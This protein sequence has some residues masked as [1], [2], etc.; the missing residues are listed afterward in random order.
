MPNLQEFS[1]IKQA[2]EGVNELLLQEQ[3]QQTEL[4]YYQAEI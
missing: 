2:C 3:I 1:N 4:E